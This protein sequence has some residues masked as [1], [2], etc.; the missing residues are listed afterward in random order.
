[1]QE[2]RRGLAFVLQLLGGGTAGVHQQS[3]R[4]WLLGLTREDCDLLTSPVVVNFEIVFL[5]GADQFTRLVLHRRDHPDQV[6]SRFE[7]D[8]LGW[9]RL[10]PKQNAHKRG[11]D[12][13]SEPFADAVSVPAVG[14]SRSHSPSTHTSP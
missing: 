10:C 7:R 1:M 6:Y 5:E 2:L 8:L 12:P 13:H 3:D 11:K 14:T 9:R 4:E